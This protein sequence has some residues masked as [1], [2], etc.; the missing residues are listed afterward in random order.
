MFFWKLF[1]GNF[2]FVAL[3]SMKYFPW[4][5]PLLLVA[6]QPK[7]PATQ[8][9]S[10]STAAPVA[11]NADT[12][13]QSPELAP[14]TDSIRQFPNSP[15]LYYRRGLLLF[16][17]QPALA[18]A[19]LEKAAAI[20]PTV[21]D[22]AAGAGEAAIN[23]A[24]YPKAIGYFRQALHASPKDAYLK[25]RLALALIENKQYNSADSAVA[26]LAKDPAAQDRA[27]YLKAR[28]AEEQKDTTAAIQHLTQAIDFAGANS[29]FDAVM[30]LGDLLSGRHQAKCLEY[31]TLASQLDETS[32]DPMFSA[33][34]FL[35][36]QHNYTDAIN[37]YK[38]CINADAEY[39]NAYF[40][41]G[42]IARMQQ[43]WKEGAMYYGMA[44]KT[45]PTSASAYYLRGTCEEKLGNKAAAKDDYYKA[46][47]FKKSYPEAAA[48]LERVKG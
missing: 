19:D 17:T 8:Q 46:L 31:Y 42:D 12:V 22:F 39:T 18:L 21:P 45:A 27:G 4:L 10:D 29:Q 48:A 30:E 3:R 33:G 32:G 38:Q 25:Y 24:L 26:D 47:S 34:E 37:A 7:Q 15:T 44:A 43:R 9:A 1:V 11:V 35:Q 6:C 5:L 20:N 16:N 40:A 23:N 28:I 14:I 13:F 2:P 36:T 41:L